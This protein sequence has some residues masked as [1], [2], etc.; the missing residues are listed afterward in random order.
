MADIPMASADQGPWTAK[1]AAKAPEAAT[2]SPAPERP[3]LRVLKTDFVAAQRANKRNTLILIVVLI[4]LAGSL[5]YLLGLVFDTYINPDPERLEDLDNLRIGAFLAV[6]SVAGVII[7]GGLMSIGL[8][9]SAVAF[10]AGGRVMMSL[11]GAEEVTKEQEPMLH[12]VVEEMAIA[13]GLPKPKVVV[14]HT[15]ALNAFAAG[16]EPESA[17]IG[18]TRGLLMELDRDELQGVIAHEMSHILNW[19]TRY[20]TAVGI[21]VGL[22]A[23]VCDGVLRAGRVGFGSGGSSRGSKGKG[24]A[25]ALIIILVVFAVLA[26]IAAQMV[27]FAVSRQREYLADATSVQLTRNPLGLMHALQKLHSDPQ[28]FF[29]ANR[30]TQH[31]FIVNPIKHFSAD[32]SELMATHPA[33]EDRIDR[34]S[35]LGA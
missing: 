11:T 34:L 13:A 5:G 12:N 22:I 18:V 20:M 4:A 2:V 10:A 17:V 1:P 14:I 19:D 33:I 7:S 31:M 16:M 8:T 15:G 29:G 9:A 3:A 32:A 30:A 35:T 25:A 27:R 28:P 24:G 21:L 26:P 6:P 23:L